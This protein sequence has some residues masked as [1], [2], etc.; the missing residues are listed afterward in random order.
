LLLAWMAL[1]GP[2][3]INTITYGPGGGG[4]GNGATSAHTRTRTFVGI[5][6]RT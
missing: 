2:L 6:V 4:G 3:S 1:R 5:E